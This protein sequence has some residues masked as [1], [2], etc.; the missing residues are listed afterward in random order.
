LRP[1]G[2]CPQSPSPRYMRAPGDPS[3]RTGVRLRAP[4]TTGPRRPLMP[5]T[6]RLLCSLPLA[7]CGAVTPG[8][9]RLPRGQAQFLPRLGD[10]HHPRL[11]RREPDGLPPEP[12]PQADARPVDRSALDREGHAHLLRDLSDQLRVRPDVDREGE[13]PVSRLPDDDMAD[14]ARRLDDG[15]QSADLPGFQSLSAIST[16]ARPSSMSAQA[17]R[18][19]DVKTSRRRVLVTL[20]QVTH[21]KRGG[22]P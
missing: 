21:S 3:L 20:P 7:G 1:P 6:V 18:K 13:E 5:P 15:V 4:R 8:R 14:V 11:R 17:S 12:R 2:L 19:T 10:Q 16:M 9:P 22:G